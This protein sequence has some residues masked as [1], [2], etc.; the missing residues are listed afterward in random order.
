[1]KELEMNPYVIQIDKFVSSLD[2]LSKA[3]LDLD[4]KKSFFSE[5]QV[6]HIYR[7]CQC[8]RVACSNDESAQWWAS[9]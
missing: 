1:M 4:E 9:L 8:A 7:W 3:F 5:E 6:L 2:K